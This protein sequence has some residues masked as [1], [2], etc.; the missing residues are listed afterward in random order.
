MKTLLDGAVYAWLLIALLAVN[1]GCKKP[2]DPGQTTPPDSTKIV[3]AVPPDWVDSVLGTYVGMCSV[4]EEQYRNGQLYKY[5]D[6]QGP[7][8]FDIYVSPY[9]PVNFFTFGA[10]HVFGTRTFEFDTSCLSHAYESDDE[11]LIP[12]KE[13]FS[14][15]AFYPRRDSI[16]FYF[17]FSD[18]DLVNGESSLCRFYGRKKP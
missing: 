11:C 10:R 7:D 3:V 1:S 5:T 14:K 9:M 8:T 15:L 17:E 2:D 4:H 16:E 13:G 6:Y 12:S 18:H